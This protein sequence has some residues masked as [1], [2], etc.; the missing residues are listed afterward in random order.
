M[1]LIISVFA[2]GARATM[3]AAERACVTKT[4]SLPVVLREGNRRGELCVCARVKAAAASRKIHYFHCATAKTT[5]L[6][7]NVSF[8]YIRDGSM[9]F[10]MTKTDY[11]FTKCSTGTKILC[12]LMFLCYL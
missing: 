8:V 1:C 11:Q 2:G 10:A 9:G 7:L 3:R 5:N 12:S 6:L 4:F